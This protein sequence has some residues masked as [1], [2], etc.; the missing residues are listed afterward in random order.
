[1]KLLVEVLAGV[2]ACGAVYY[3][4]R[5]SSPERPAE[6]TRRDAALVESSSSS[7]Q[8]SPSRRA[9]EATHIRAS[10]AA[11]TPTSPADEAAMATLRNALIVA[12][13]ADMQRRGE[14]V[15]KCLADVKLSGVQKLRFSVDI[16]STPRDATAGQWQFVEIID[17][18]PL[19][20]SFAACAARALGGGQHLVP[21]QDLRF[22]EYRGELEIV[23]TI[24]A[25]SSD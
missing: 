2:A 4:A 23:Y 18:E 24:P 15:V 19:P 10:S 7:V 25:P 6:T 11:D 13:S 20:A 22:P 1:M 16:V 3:F 8:L 21:P 9:V 17:G 12:T 14:D 5:P